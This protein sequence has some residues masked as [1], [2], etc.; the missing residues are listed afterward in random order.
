MPSVTVPSLTAVNGFDPAYGELETW[1]VERQR[2]DDLRP[3]LANL[4][5]LHR[6][7]ADLETDVLFFSELRD[8]VVK[9][10]GRMSDDLRDAE[11]ETVKAERADAVAAS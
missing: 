7:A 9:L 4:G 1:L 11:W 8:D 2:A 3:T 6:L 5:R 10:A